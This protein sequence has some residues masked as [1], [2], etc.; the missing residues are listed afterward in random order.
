MRNAWLLLLKEWLDYASKL[1][2]KSRW[3][4]YEHNISSPRVHYKEYLVSKI[5]KH[6]LDPIELYETIKIQQILRRQEL[7]IPEKDEENQESEEDYRKRLIEVS[8]Y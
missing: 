2:G 8:P 4:E 1:V 5:N 6:N 3:R 7:E